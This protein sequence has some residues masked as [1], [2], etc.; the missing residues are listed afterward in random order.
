[1]QLIALIYKDQHVNNLRHLLAV[2]LETELSESSE[3][4]ESN[5]SPQVLEIISIFVGKLVN[6]YFF[7]S[8]PQWLLLQPRSDVER[9]GRFLRRAGT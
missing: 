5:T 3:D 4:N 7:F 8:G 9:D 2:W 6:S 1:M